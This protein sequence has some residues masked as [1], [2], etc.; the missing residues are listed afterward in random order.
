MTDLIYQV[1]LFVL[2]CFYTVNGIISLSFRLDVVPSIGTVELKQWSDFVIHT[3]DYS[4]YERYDSS[5][6]YY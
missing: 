4:D 2:F 6:F 5:L 1:L 3:C